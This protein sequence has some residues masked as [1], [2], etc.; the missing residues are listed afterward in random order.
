MKNLINNLCYKLEV[1]EE[2][3][4]KSEK[5]RFKDKTL[6]VFTIDGKSEK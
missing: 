4:S 1:I 5:V 2:V 3:R 6:Q